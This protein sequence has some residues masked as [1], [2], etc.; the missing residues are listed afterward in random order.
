MKPAWF[1][2]L[3]LAFFGAVQAADDRGVAELTLGGAKITVDYGRPELRG[4]N[5]LSLAR[6]GMVWR[7]GMNR[8]TELSTAADLD[9]G[10]VNVPK[11]DYS[12]FAKK[13]G[14]EEWV[15]LFNSQTGLWGTSGYDSAN[16]VAQVPLLFARTEDSQDALLIKF[17]KRS[18]NDAHFVVQWGNTELRTS[19]R[20]AE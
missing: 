15:L 19:F 12:L 3:T 10:G 14:G 2:C 6:P 11:G 9:F 4:R 13:L 16:D 7:L 8:A 1:L 5:M 20:V 18:E 17:E